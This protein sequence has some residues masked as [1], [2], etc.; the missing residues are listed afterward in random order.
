MKKNIII[1]ILVVLL[2][3]SLSFVFF[4]S[5]SSKDE[6]S[7]LSQ[8]NYQFTDK[9]TRENSA[10]NS[11]ETSSAV[12]KVTPKYE[13]TAES[14]IVSEKSSAYLTSFEQRSDGYYY[15]SFDYV[16]FGQDQAGAV[17]PVNNN[18]KTRT[19]RASKNLKVGY[20]F[21]NEF[22]GNKFYTISQYLPLLTKKGNFLWNPTI[23]EDSSFLHNGLYQIK[24]E[25]GE[26]VQMYEGGD[27]SKPQG[28]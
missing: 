20:D 17:T 1:A 15:L 5:K 25:K 9:D 4:G 28:L 24:I 27:F 13:D 23:Q 18:S 6:I 8:L 22:N 3:V 14:K 10:Q 26:V 2:V 16:S 11:M 12:G 19:F 21:T 7:D